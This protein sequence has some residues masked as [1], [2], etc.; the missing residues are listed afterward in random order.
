MAENTNQ[1]SYFICSDGHRMS[2]NLW[3]PDSN[4][5]PKAFVQILHGMAE[6]S[7]RYARFAKLLNKNG[8]AVF[9][10]DHRGHG[11]SIEDD[12]K[13]YFTSS[14]GWNRI[15]A[16]AS[17][18]AAFITSEYAVST[19][20]LFGHSMGSFL[21]RTVM[22]NNPQFYS[23]VVIM[24]TASSQGIVGKVGKLVAKRQISRKGAKE[25]GFLMNKLSFGS[26]N[27]G[28][29]TVRTSYDWLSRDDREVDKYIED[30]LCGFVCTNGFYYDLL[31]GIEMANDRKRSKT[32]P[33][34]LPL[35]IVSGSSDPVG[36]KGKGVKKVY[37]LY[38]KAGIKDLTLKL[39][40]EAR[41]ELL[42]EIN[43][44]EVEQDILK[45]FEAHV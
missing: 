2:Y 42:N 44:E 8:Y 4:T 15:A 3:L 37:E 29:G 14:D 19:T 16:D 35:L 6:H 39:Y 36:A 12:L 41:H 10:G 26:Y 9:A 5:K 38:R 27:K 32:L 21:A 18:L 7:D 33:S 40:P 30:E 22:V 25:K 17:E 24:G 28:F 1:K 45:W 13:G 11:G 31:T 23:G 20:F 43:R 34:D